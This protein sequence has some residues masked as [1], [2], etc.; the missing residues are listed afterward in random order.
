ML[1]IFL[2]LPSMTIT[3]GVGAWRVRESISGFTLMFGTGGMQGLGFFNLFFD[4]MLPIFALTTVVLLSAFN[5]IKASAKWITLAVAGA[6]CYMALSC[7]IFIGR[8]AVLILMDF[9]F[10]ANVSV[11]VGLILSF[12]IW[13]VVAAAAVLDFLNI[14]IVKFR[15][16]A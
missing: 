7:L 8:L 5:V 15:G 10:N 6:G 11:G 9:G 3:E 4:L 13:L 2:A 16:Q 14:H 12:I 1:L